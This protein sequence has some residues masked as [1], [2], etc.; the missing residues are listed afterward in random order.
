MTRYSGLFCVLG[1]LGAG[2]AWG[3][4]Q[5]GDGLRGDYYEGRE[6]DRLVASRRDATLN[7]DWHGTRPVA[8]LTPKDFSVRW[9]GWLVPPTTGR[10]VLHISAD[11]GIRLWLN[12][13][14]LLDD[15]RG[16]SLNYYQVE[17]DLKAGERYALRVDYCQHDSATQARLAWL[18]PAPAPTDSQR[19]RRNAAEHPVGAVVIPTRYLFSHYPTVVPPQRDTL[20]AR[21]PLS[22]PAPPQA[23][24][25][26]TVGPSRAALLEPAPPTRQK[27]RPVSYLRATAVASAAT[28]RPA[29]F[30]VCGSR[31]GPGGSAR[32]PP[33]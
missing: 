9:T 18:P 28:R 22:S 25:A 27:L 15:W 10:Y 5:R 23:I 20:V 2:N 17:V 24:A 33:G 8:G 1:L 31:F 11:D 30:P 14:Q 6:F 19:H 21:Q 13:R 32:Y 29:A 3:Q 26:R 16:R 12:D 7:F 4:A